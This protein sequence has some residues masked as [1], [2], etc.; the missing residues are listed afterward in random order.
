MK[1]FLRKL[2]LP[3]FVKDTR[4]TASLIIVLVLSLLGAIIGTLISP[5]FGLAMVLLFILT[6]IFV[7]YG[8]YV[9]AGKLNEYAVNI[10]KE[11]RKIGGKVILFTCRTDKSLEL[12]VE[13][14]KKYGLEFDAVN[15][16]VDSV[17]TGWC[18]NYN[19]YSCSN[20]VT[21]DLYIDD[22]SYD[23]YGRNIDWYQVKRLIFSKE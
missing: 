6:I 23:R 3:E 15:K 2:E 13:N 12:A 9:L 7:I 11:Y 17:A 5:L 4:L 18:R 8:I 14:C 10:L 20:K 21:A 22:R 16:D 19:T 1:G